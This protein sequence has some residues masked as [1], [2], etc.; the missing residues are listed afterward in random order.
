MRR[1]C[2]KSKTIEA[3]ISLCYYYYYYYFDF[4]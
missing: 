1:L 4:R 3:T 2:W